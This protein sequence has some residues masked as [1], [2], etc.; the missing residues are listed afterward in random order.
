LSDTRS[1][2][3]RSRLPLLSGLER[4]IGLRPGLKLG[5]EWR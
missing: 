3:V 5:I 2:L 4:Q 1:I